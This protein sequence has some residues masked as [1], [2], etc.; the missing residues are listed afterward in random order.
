MSPHLSM[1]CHQKQRTHPLRVGPLVHQVTHAQQQV[2]STPILKL[3]EQRLQ[4][5]CM[6]WGLEWNAMAW[7]VKVRHGMGVTQLL[8]QRLQLVCSGMPWSAR[9]GTA[10]VVQ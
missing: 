2:C 6:A 1:A 3:L 7:D 10:Q 5:V 8:E 9:L 4:L